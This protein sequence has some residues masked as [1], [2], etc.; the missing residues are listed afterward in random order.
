M[1][2]KVAKFKGLYLQ[3]DFKALYLQVDFS[4]SR[5]LWTGMADGPLIPKAASLN[6]VLRFLF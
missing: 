4:F 6:L 2:Q 5:A 3:V 1:W